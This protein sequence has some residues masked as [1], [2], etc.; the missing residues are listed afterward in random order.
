MISCKVYSADG[1][2][3]CDDH[4]YFSNKV[5]NLTY[6]STDAIILHPIYKGKISS[7]RIN[8]INYEEYLRKNR[9]VI[10]SEPEEKQL[11]MYSF[12]TKTMMGTSY[13]A[14]REDKDWYLDCSKEGEI[15]RAEKEVNPLLKVIHYLPRLL[16]RVNAMRRER[17]Y[18]NNVELLLLEPDGTTAL[19]VILEKK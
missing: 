12:N 11:L 16:K 5:G 1:K 15:K 8:G 9:W 18:Y 14:F 17:I 2:L 13:V 3:V 10:A 6:E 4:K 7:C 19:K